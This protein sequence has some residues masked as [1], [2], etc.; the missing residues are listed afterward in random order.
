VLPRPSV[1][2]VTLSAVLALASGCLSVSDLAHIVDADAGF[3]AADAASAGDALAANPPDASSAGDGSTAELTDA[4]AGSDPPLPP[5]DAGRDP[6]SID[7]TPGP[8]EP[9]RLA[10]DAT[11]ACTADEL[12]APDGFCL[13]RCESH[14][15]CVIAATQRAIDQLWVIDGVTYL[16]LAAQ[17]DAAG[18]DLHNAELRRLEDNGE[19]TLL[20]QNHDFEA[21]SCD[22]AWLY[23]RSN[24]KIWRMPK[25]GSV[26]PEALYATVCNFLLFEGNQ[27]AL[28]DGSKLSVGSS[29]GQAPLRPIAELSSVAQDCS[30]LGYAEQRVFWV[31]ERTIV[32][33]SV[34]VEA[35]R[36]YGFGGTSFLAVVPPYVYSRSDDG[37][38]F[39]RHD[40]GDTTQR[41]M[42]TPIDSHRT[43]TSLQLHGE[44]LYRVSSADSHEAFYLDIE[45]WS[46]HALGT[47]QT[48]ADGFRP[49]SAYPIVDTANGSIYSGPGASSFAVTATHLLVLANHYPVP[50]GSPSSSL[51]Y[52]LPLPV[53]P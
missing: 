53:A 42:V 3:S 47:K 10:C 30:P 7:V 20:A 38:S 34:A 16:K 28:F 4:A 29:D 18:N 15:A 27:L 33:S 5:T 43:R 19:L 35:E 12:C 9:A 13:P 39:F 6:K 26:A 50:D 32:G 25:A 48:I 21:L 45:R 51:L 24:D 44:W 37:E 31:R 36:T 41:E 11:H 1:H 8:M 22:G 17:R 2:H 40:F 52:R 46:L 23:W 14:G 49:P